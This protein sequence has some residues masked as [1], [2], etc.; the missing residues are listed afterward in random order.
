MKKCTP[1][2]PAT[3]KSVKRLRWR[4]GPLRS[5]PSPLLQLP[6]SLPSPQSS[7]PSHLRVSGMHFPLLHLKLSAAQPGERAEAER[8]QGTNPNS[9]PNTRLCPSPFPPKTRKA[10]AATTYKCPFPASPISSSLNCTPPPIYAALSSPKAGVPYTSAHPRFSPPGSR[11]GLLRGLEEAA[12]GEASPCPAAGWY[13]GFLARSF[14]APYLPSSA[15]RASIAL[16]AL[17][18]PSALSARGA[19]HLLHCSSSLLSPQSFTLSQTQNLGLHQPFWHLNCWSVQ[20]EKGE[21]EIRGEICKGI[22]GVASDPS[23]IPSTAASRENLGGSR[24]GFA[25]TWEQAHQK[26]P[27]QLRATHAYINT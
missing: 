27:R 19:S 12:P 1:G 20:A 6:S 2:C 13:L 15:P 25:S 24:S 17:L 21:R 9:T 22:C 18:E 23:A 26:T 10:S 8:R 16:L 4:G 7:L 3:K 11:S 14:P 5:P